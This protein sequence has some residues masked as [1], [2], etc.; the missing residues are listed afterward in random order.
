[1]Y[2]KIKLALIGL[3]VLTVCALMGQASN[4]VAQTNAAVSA[5]NV[6]RRIT[7]EESIELATKRVLD[8]IAQR[9]N[10]VRHLSKEDAE[11]VAKIRRNFVPPKPWPDTS[12]K[13][14][15]LKYCAEVLRSAIDTKE[16]DL[17]CSQL[18]NQ[19]EAVVALK[20]FLK[21]AMSNLDEF[22]TI[23]TGSEI[24]TTV[25]SEGYR[26]ELSTVQ[27]YYAFT[28]WTTNNLPSVVRSFN[29]RQH[30]GGSLVMGGAFY[31]N[32]KLEVFMVPSLDSKGI[33][34]ESGFSF[35]EDGKL[36]Y[37]WIAPKETT[38]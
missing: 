33:L 26:A 34:R 6:T 21:V 16:I 35:K 22:A 3:V 12:D 32:G 30:G 11:L 15:T 19:P 24:T 25:G 14:V 28:F 7:Q 10:V 31:E 1:M 8:I 38:P 4:V 36:D 37:H 17:A 20:D 29:K 5:T 23:L 13:Q 18:T 9:T 27:N 2:M